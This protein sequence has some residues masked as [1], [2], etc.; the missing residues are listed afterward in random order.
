VVFGEPFSL[1]R[2]K[3]GEAGA[4]SLADALRVNTTLTALTW[5]AFIYLFFVFVY[6][7]LFLL[8]SSPP[9]FLYHHRILASQTHDHSNKPPPHTHFAFN[10]R[11]VFGEPFSLTRNKIGDAAATSLASALRVNTTLTT[12]W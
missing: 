6:V 7:F 2:N 1:A 11:V 4:A 12:L 10:P 8:I 5:V 3:I 9:L